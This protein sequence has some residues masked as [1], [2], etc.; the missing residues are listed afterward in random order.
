MDKYYELAD[1]TIALFHETVARLAF[2]MRINFKLIGHAKQK[3]LISIKKA[4]DIL[5]YVAQHQVIVFINQD[6]LD[7]LDVD[8]TA[9]NVLFTEE[10]N[11]VQTNMDKGTIKIGKPDLNTSTSVIDK[12]GLDEV[13]RVKD[14]ERL[15]QEQSAEKKEEEGNNITETSTY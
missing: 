9:I 12:F 4:N 11:N 8:P 10:L 15:T 2:P 1:E 5:E 3:K 7:Q 13:K 6:L 14:L